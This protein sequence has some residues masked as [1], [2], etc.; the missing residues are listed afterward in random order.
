MGK[1]K[2]YLVAFL[3]AALIIFVVFVIWFAWFLSGVD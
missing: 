1:F 2:S 3:G